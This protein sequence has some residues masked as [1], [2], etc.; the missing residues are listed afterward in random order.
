VKINEKKRSSSKIQSLSNLKI[1]I[2]IHATFR[3]VE[4]HLFMGMNT[5]KSVH[6]LVK[7]WRRYEINV[8]ISYGYNCGRRR[9]IFAVSV[10][11][12][13][14]FFIKQINQIKS[15]KYRAGVGAC[16]CWRLEVGGGRL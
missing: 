11:D 6:L 4:M 16:G 8:F 1:L 15:R 2:N 13:Q 10:R 14:L 12:Y 9:A 5:H 7:V 3:Y